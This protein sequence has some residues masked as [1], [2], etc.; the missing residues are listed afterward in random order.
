VNTL[1]GYY[2]MA[3]ISTDPARNGQRYFSKPTQYFEKAIKLDGANPR[4][5][6]LRAFYVLQLPEFIRPTIDVKREADKAAEL[7]ASESPGIEKPY[8]GRGFYQA[9]TGAPLPGT[10][11]DQAGS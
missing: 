3:L 1:Y 11:G 4:P 7:F 6:I 2:Y 8:W 9:L 10:D 5:V